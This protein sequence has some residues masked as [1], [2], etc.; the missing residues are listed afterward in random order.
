M[1]SLAVHLVIGL[2]SCPW[3]TTLRSLIFFFSTLIDLSSFPRSPPLDPPQPPTHALIRRIRLRTK[4]NLIYLQ[5]TKQLARRQ[6]ERDLRRSRGCASLL[7]NVSRSV[8]VRTGPDTEREMPEVEA[9]EARD[10]CSVRRAGTYIHSPPPVAP[11]LVAPVS[12][13]PR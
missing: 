13:E 8:V 11:V 2:R 4:L 12:P 1:S 7:A 3:M 9:E 6:R 5:S 10:Q